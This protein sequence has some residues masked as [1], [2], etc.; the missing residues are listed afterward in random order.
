MNGPHHRPSKSLPTRRTVL[1]VGVAGSLGLTLTDALRAEAGRPSGHRA[2]AD[3]VILLWL[4]GGPATID[5]WD[6]KPDAAKHIRGEFNP[7]DTRAKGVR[8]CEHLPKVAA[9]MDRCAV[10][11]SL[12]HAITDHGA[13]ASYLATGRLPDAALKYPSLGAI[14]TKLLPATNGVPSYIALDRAA[15][16][17]GGAGFLGAAGQPFEAELSTGRAEGVSLPTGFTPDLLAD[18]DRLRAASTPGSVAWTIPTSRPGWIGSSNKP[19]TS[20]GRTASGRRSTCRPRPMRC[21]SSTAGRRSAAAHSPPADSLKPGPGSS[22]SAGPGGTRTPATSGH[23]AGNSC[24]TSTRS[25]RPLWA[26]STTAACWTG[27]WYT[28]LVSSGGPRG[29]MRAPDGT[30]GRGRWPSCWRAAG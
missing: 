8:V 2:D 7:I 21:V 23:S 27:R 1:R 30:T 18:R 17:P 6:L 10:V 20:Y 19:S 29:S 14:T 5:M 22:P 24:P 13:G 3:A 9:V 16:F 12:G 26:T 4:G 15:G 11:R 25:F 28:V